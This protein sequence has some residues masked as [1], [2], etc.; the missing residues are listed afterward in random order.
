MA[1]TGPSIVDYLKNIGE[2]SS[3]TSRAKRAAQMGIKDYRGTA[4]Q[5]AKMLST[6]RD[7][8][9]TATPAPASPASSTAGTPTANTSIAPAIVDSDNANKVQHPDVS[10]INSYDFV[11]NSLNKYTN[12]N[13][14]KIDSLMSE[15]LDNKPFDYSSWN[16]ESDAGF[17]AFR[18]SAMDLGN[19]AYGSSVAGMSRP[20][21]KDSSIAR[22]VGESSRNTY[23]NQIQ[24]AIPTFM[25]NARQDFQQN[26]LNKYKNL[27]ALGGLEETDYNRAYQQGRDYIQD[28]GY[29]PIDASLIDANNPLRQYSDM[30]GGYQAE[31]DR[32]KA[33]NPDDPLIPVLEALRWEK[34]QQNPDLMEQYGQGATAPL[35]LP[36]QATQESAFDRAMRIAQEERQGRYTDAQ[37][38]NMEADNARMAAGSSGLGGTADTGSIDQGI[39]L[40]GMLQ[41]GNPVQWL[42]DNAD[43]LGGD[44]YKFLYTYAKGTSYDASQLFA[45]ATPYQKQ[46]YEQLKDTYMGGE[47]DWKGQYKDNPQAALDWLTQNA[48]S[49][50]NLIGPLYD[51]LVDEIKAK[52][53]EGMS[54]KLNNILSEIM[55]SSKPMEALS[56]M[57]SEG[58]LTNLDDIQKLISLVKAMAG[59]Q[60]SGSDSEYDRIKNEA[61]GT[62]TP[63]PTPY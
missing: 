19:R 63:T 2:D 39:L 12:P 7:S 25:N 10:G 11:S 46:M 49:N 36:T 50:K 6:L 30:G 52:I 42:E 8:A 22:Q 35:G 60:A 58:K 59:T 5:N 34:L 3:Y 62:P 17:V 48:D 56:K 1:Y 47:G 21:I 43:W 9:V 57:V 14:E 4:D 51:V 61:S 18:N 27:E 24:D 38:S 41:S 28:T 29:M 20:G 54:T 13:R 16:P 53:T 32:R 33:A 23:I 55:A 15:F 40:Q 26:I 37:I 45:Q 31:I 44:D